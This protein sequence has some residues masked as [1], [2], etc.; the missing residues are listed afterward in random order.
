MVREEDGEKASFF[1]TDPNAKLFSAG[2]ALS[3]S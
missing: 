3:Q 1:P 2:K